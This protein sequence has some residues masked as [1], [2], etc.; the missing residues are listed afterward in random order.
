M[1]SSGLR[2]RPY[3]KSRQTPPHI[4][5]GP[6]YES[7]RN[8]GTLHRHH[9]HTNTNTHICSHTHTQQSTELHPVRTL[10]LDPKCPLYR[11]VACL[12]L[13][14]GGSCALDVHSGNS[15]TRGTALGAR[16]AFFHLQPAP[17]LAM[18]TTT[19]SPTICHG[20]SLPLC[21]STASVYAH[22][23]IHTQCLSAH[24]SLQVHDGHTHRQ[25]AHSCV[26]SF[27]QVNHCESPLRHPPT[28][29]AQSQLISGSPRQAQHPHE[30]QLQTCHSEEPH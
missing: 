2:E 1:L 27:S 8:A 25:D 22:G 10:Q 23:H 19:Q 3:L 13:E 28:S 17:Q 7:S 30:S 21:T 24:N 15:K 11:Q 18:D 16:P 14:V 29:I 5:F 20:A 12:S 4:N 6:S 26:S 9:S